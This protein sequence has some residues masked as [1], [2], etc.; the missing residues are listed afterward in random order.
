MT[1]SFAVHGQ[2]HT[3]SPATQSSHES[4]RDRQAAADRCRVELAQSRSIQS[5][6]THLRSTSVLRSPVSCFAIAAALLH[7]RASP[8]MVHARAT[9]PTYAKSANS[10]STDDFPTR[11]RLLLSIVPVP[12]PDQ[13][14]H[15]GRRLAVLGEVLFLPAKHP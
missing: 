4:E 15:R 3:P 5:L 13:T 14:H 1:R 10:A 6:R 11:R 8:S 2:S 7:A 12:L 9:L